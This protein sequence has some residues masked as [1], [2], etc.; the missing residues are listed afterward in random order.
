MV[1]GHF[2]VDVVDACN[3][4]CI[5]VKVLDRLRDDLIIE[6]PAGSPCFPSN[7]VVKYHLGPE[8]IQ[9]VIREYGINARDPLFYDCDTHT[10]GV[11]CHK[12]AM[13]PD[14]GCGQG[15]VGGGGIV[16]PPG[17]RG[18]QGETGRDGTGVVSVRLGSNNELYVLLT[19]G[20][21]IEAGV[22]GT[23]AGRDGIDGRPGRDGADGVTPTVREVERV[24]LEETT[25]P[26]TYKI[27]VS[28]TGTFSGVGQE[29]GQFDVP[30][31]RDT[32]VSEME[33]LRSRMVGIE[34]Q[35]AGANRRSDE[36]AR[37]IELLQQQNTNLQQ[38]ITTL[39]ATVT[40]LQTTV[41]A[42]VN[43]P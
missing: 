37:T 20:R 9:A 29:V 21:E 41:N 1:Q 17:E 26:G 42:L 43:R 8:Y 39:N 35:I 12:L 2:F 14:C 25:N 30:A 6:P 28:Y 24:W 4:K 22:I 31:V 13:D 40:T 33:T 10:I 27:L 7:S 3:G 16:G 36:L 18:P 15:G 34:A 32:A 38:Q 19:S 11:D 5:T 23:V